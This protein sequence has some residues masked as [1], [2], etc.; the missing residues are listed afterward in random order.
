MWDWV[1]RDTKYGSLSSVAHSTS[2]PESVNTS[3]SSF[4]RRFIIVGVC[5]KCQAP[6]VKAFAV[7]SVPDAFSNELHADIS[8]LTGN[9]KQ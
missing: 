6:V 3:I 7:V 8:R 9:K 5:S 4:R 1:V 2:G